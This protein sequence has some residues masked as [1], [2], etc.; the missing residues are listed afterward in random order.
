MLLE[1]T[2]IAVTDMLTNSFSSLSSALMQS[3]SLNKFAH[4]EITLFHRNLS[5][6]FSLCLFLSVDQPIKHLRH[7]KKMNETQSR[8]HK[9]KYT[10]TPQSQTSR[11]IWLLTQ[12][13]PELIKYKCVFMC[14]EI[15][16]FMPTVSFDFGCRQ[17][18]CFRLLA[19]YWWMACFFPR[20]IYLLRMHWKAND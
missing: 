10:H 14:K 6:T 20:F 18:S 13:L 11:Q 15:C 17:L 1:S 12:K 2:A 7:H 19:P 9:P 3:I 8:V 5:H 4:F 16:M